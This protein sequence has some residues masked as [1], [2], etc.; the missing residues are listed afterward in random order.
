M[1]HTDYTKTQI[2]ENLQLLKVSMDARVRRQ[3]RQAI[4]D[5]DTAILQERLSEIVQD[6]TDPEILA[7]IAEILLERDYE[8]GIA[9]VLPLLGTEEAH[10]RRHICGLLS[11]Y[12]DSN[13][14]EPL[15]QRLQTDTSA[16]VRVIAAFALGKI[17]DERALPALLVAQE[18][19]FDIDFEG[20]PVNEEARRAIISIQSK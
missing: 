3:A 19:D 1:K 7:Y 17:Q 11:N 8:S 14:V 2:I 15:I 18:Q 10:L 4:L 5:L 12:S 6:E 20:T 16:D 13:T 9:L